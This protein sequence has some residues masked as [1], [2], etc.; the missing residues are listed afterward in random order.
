MAAEGLAAEEREAVLE[1]ALLDAVLAV[2]VARCV[3]DCAGLL[4]ALLDA[5][6]CVL[7]AVACVLGAEV[8]LVPQALKVQLSAKAAPS[9]EA[10]CKNVELIG[11]RSKKANYALRGVAA[12]VES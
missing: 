10:A 3:L 11:S 2:V 12:L 7:G 6:A 9:A 4:V 5:V 1:R 8:S